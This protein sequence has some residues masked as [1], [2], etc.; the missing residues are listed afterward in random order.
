MNI[1]IIILLVIGSIIALFLIIASLTKKAYTLQK[2][3]IINA[4]KQEVFNYMKLIKNQEQYSVWVTKD[5]NIKLVYTGTDGTVGFK[6]AWESNN[7]NVGVGEQELKKIT[8]GDSTEVEIRFKK[9]FEGTSWAANK[10]T[11]TADGKTLLTQ[12]F[13]GKSK[14]PMNIMNL[15]MDKLVGKDMQT[16]LENLK[17][18]LEK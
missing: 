8:D 4:P 1:F 11:T 2:Q 15:F 13:S 17:R 12:T 3:V 9:P 14:F 10:L 18:N 16:N 5:P 7:K 6:S